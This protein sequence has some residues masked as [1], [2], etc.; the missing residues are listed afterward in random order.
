MSDLHRTDG[1]VA[2]LTLKFPLSCGGAL[3]EDRRVGDRRAAALVW[4]AARALWRRR[5]CRRLGGHYLRFFWEGEGRLGGLKIVERGR[6]FYLN[7]IL[8]QRQESSII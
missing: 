7:D 4:P 1:E 5:G 2:H 6:N 3:A 8:W